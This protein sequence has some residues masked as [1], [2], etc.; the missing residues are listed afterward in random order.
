MEDAGMK[1]NQ[2]KINTHIWERQQIRVGKKFEKTMKN[3]CQK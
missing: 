3:Y 1:K 2:Q